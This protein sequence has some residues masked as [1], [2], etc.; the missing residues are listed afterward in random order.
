MMEPLRATLFSLLAMFGLSLSQ[1][2]ATYQGYGEGEYVLVSSQLAGTIESVEVIRGQSVKKND[3]LFTLE[4]RAEQAAVDQARAEA[5]RAEALLADLLKARRQPEL[6]AL[7]AQRNEAAAAVRIAEINL[8]R[9]KHQ[10]KAQAISQAVVDADNATLAQTRA[11]LA[12]TEASLASGK[13]ST[14]RSDAIRAAQADVAASNAA[15]AQAQWKLDRKTV[16]AP[17]D[18]LI[19]DTLYRPGEF[20]DPG[21]A[22]V[23]LLPP[24]NLKVRFFVPATALPNLSIGMPVT[25]LMTGKDGTG[26]SADEKLAARISYIAPQAEYSPPELYN[27]DN[28]DKLLFMIEATPDRSPERIHPGLPVDVRIDKQSRAS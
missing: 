2:G 12:E 22:V 5:E 18:G 17:A 13:L 28:R 9:D 19:F 15:L 10:L 7:M 25:I 6:D 3:A 11:R 24:T 21:K 27:R 14:G 8:E 20:V 26:Q 4:H 23:S 1:D 16:T